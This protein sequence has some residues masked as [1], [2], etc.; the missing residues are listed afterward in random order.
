LSLVVTHASA[1]WVWTGGNNGGTWH[2]MTITG[3][4]GEAIAA[5]EAMRRLEYGKGRGFGSVK[6]RAAIGG[7][8]WNTSVFPSKASGG[9]LLPVKLAVRSA[10]DLAE[11]DVAEVALELL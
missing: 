5:H 2:F 6:V 10:E 8:S 1:L 3:D 7:T 11:G 4:A 9:Y